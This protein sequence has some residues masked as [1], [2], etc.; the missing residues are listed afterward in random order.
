VTAPKFGSG[1]GFDNIY[2]MLTTLRNFE[3]RE[4]KV[5]ISLTS[6]YTSLGQVSQVGILRAECKM[7]SVSHY[8]KMTK[9]YHMPSDTFGP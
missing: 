7:F 3:M 1:L 6:K 5:A 8:S 2:Q 4:L 9:Y